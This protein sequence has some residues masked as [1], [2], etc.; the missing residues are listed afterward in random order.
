MRLPSSPR[1]L[2]KRKVRWNL[3]PSCQRLEYPRRERQWLCTIEILSEQQR[4]LDRDKFCVC[5]S[6]SASFRS[7]CNSKLRGPSMW[8]L[9]LKPSYPGR[10]QSHVN[11]LHKLFAYILLQESILIESWICVAIIP[12]P[13]L[14]RKDHSEC[15][16][17]PCLECPRVH[18]GQLHDKDHLII[19][20]ER[21][22]V[23]DVL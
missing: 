12:H 14:R 1:K 19:S 8:G 5:Q 11:W 9:V 16:R 4:L 21:A 10:L 6:K 13:N 7:L 15:P 2:P 3:V 22:G 23:W 20:P 17:Y 18:P